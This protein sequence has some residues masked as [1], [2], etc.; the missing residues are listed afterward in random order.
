MPMEAR[1]L[2]IKLEKRVQEVLHSLLSEGY[3]V[4]FHTR[5]WRYVRLYH[6]GNH[7]AISLTVYNY[8]YTMKK[9]GRIIKTENV[10]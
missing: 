7:N 4:K 3:D 10:S 9:N 5:Y 6:N 8:G 2:S 1:L